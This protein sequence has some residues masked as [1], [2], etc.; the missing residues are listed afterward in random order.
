MI[1]VDNQ[2]VSSSMHA[3]RMLGKSPLL[4]V[5][6]GEELRGEFIMSLCPLTD[7][8]CKKI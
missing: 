1:E 8:E 2:A 7:T 4:I 6:R 3:T 5:I